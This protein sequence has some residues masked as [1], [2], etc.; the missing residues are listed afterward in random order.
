MT[1]PTLEQTSTHGQCEAEFLHTF[2]ALAAL[3]R[4]YTGELL[5]RVDNDHHLYLDCP[6]EVRPGYPRFLGAVAVMKSSVSFHFM[7]VY[8]NP[9]LLLSLS[10]ALRSRMQGKSCFTFRTID[11]EQIEELR[12][13]VQRGIALYREHGLVP[14]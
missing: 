3:L 7:P 9:E 1:H 13:L 8:T 10:A 12:R 2:T 5:V 4:P 14:A 11:T 6:T